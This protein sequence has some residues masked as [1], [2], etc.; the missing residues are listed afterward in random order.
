M[1]I[2]MS[3]MYIRICIHHVSRWRYV[4][5]MSYIYIYTYC[6]CILTLYLE[7]HTRCSAYVQGV[8][9][10]APRSLG[11]HTDARRMAFLWAS[12]VCHRE[13]TNLTNPNNISNIVSNEWIY[14]QYYVI[15]QHFMYCQ[16]ESIV[17]NVEYLVNDQPYQYYWL[18]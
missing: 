1:E 17:S 18:K 8:Q 13:A 14:Y 5:H 9:S 12:Q 4:C 10:L 6:H 3:Y 7:V 11:S 2:Y 16:A 15:F